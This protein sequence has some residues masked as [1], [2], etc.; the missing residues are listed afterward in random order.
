MA[1]G[2]RVSL[3]IPVLVSTYEYLNTIATSSRPSRTS[4]SRPARTCSLCLCVASILLQ[5]SL[6]GLARVVIL[7]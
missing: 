4:P 5:D 7:N 6:P 3:A 2:R 1:S